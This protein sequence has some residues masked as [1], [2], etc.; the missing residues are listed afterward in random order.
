MIADNRNV[1][2]LDKWQYLIHQRAANHILDGFSFVM[3]F[4][5]KSLVLVLLSG[6]YILPFR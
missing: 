3:V 6:I 1:L 4:L 5:H 2:L